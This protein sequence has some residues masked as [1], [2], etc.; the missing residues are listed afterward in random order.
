MR[1]DKILGFK[2]SFAILAQAKQKQEFGDVM[3][4]K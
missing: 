2:G 4:R 3:N 1:L